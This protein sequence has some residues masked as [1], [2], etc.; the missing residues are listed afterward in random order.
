MDTGTERHSEKCHVTMEPEIE[1]MLPPS[2]NA[3]DGQQ[4]HTLGPSK[5]GL[6][7]RTFSGNRAPAT[8]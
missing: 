2:R 3:K 7:P 6:F 8:L 1:L 4:P 5:E